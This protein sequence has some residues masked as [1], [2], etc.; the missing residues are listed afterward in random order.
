MRRFYS[1]NWWGGYGNFGIIRDYYSM[2]NITRT[3]ADCFRHRPGV[4][5]DDVS[6]HFTTIF[7]S[8]YHLQCPES[9]SRSCATVQTEYISDDVRSPFYLG[10]QWSPLVVLQQTLHHG[11]RQPYAC[12]YEATAI[13]TMPPRAGSLQSI[14]KSSTTQCLLQ[15]PY[16]TPT[17]STPAPI[18][19]SE[20]EVQSA[21]DYCSG[22]LQYVSVSTITLI[23]SE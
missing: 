17:Y 19:A 14:W 2:G 20:A 13:N 3:K 16:S 12:L 4:D 10:Q 18:G 5:D 22:L 1:K 21:R 9:R 6:Q 11:R 7:T 23:S 15:R 8:I